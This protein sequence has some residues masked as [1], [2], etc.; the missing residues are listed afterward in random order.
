MVDPY[1]NS[2]THNAIEHSTVNTIQI[3]ALFLHPPCL[4]NWICLSE[5][6]IYLVSSQSISCFKTDYVTTSQ[7]VSHGD[8]C[9]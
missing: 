2:Y 1:E 6:I 7:V 9:V 5:L 3:I 4:L 8:L